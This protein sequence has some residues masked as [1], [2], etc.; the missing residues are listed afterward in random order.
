MT[1]ACLAIRA[2]SK[3]LSQKAENA[4]FSISMKS[5]RASFEIVSKGNASILDQIQPL[6]QTEERKSKG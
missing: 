2:L 6:R 3:T 4:W 5:V 1:L